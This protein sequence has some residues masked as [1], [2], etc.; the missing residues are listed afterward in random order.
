MNVSTK[1]KEQL[2]N[3]K[4][5]LAFVGMSNSGKSYRAKVLQRELGFYRY[6]IDG[7][8]QADLGFSSMEEI[9]DWM[10]YPD[11]PTYKEREQKYL[12]LENKHT[13]LTDFDYAGNIVFDT[14]GSVVHL[15]Q[16]TKDWL[17][18]NCIVVNMEITDDMIEKMMSAFFEHP[19][20]VVWAGFFN[21]QNDETTQNALKHSYPKL[22]KARAKMYR[23]LAHISVPA[24]V[25]RDTSAQETM[26]IIANYL[27]S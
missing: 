15:P 26:N 20:P 3:N 10:G 23:E 25:L 22:L 9:S 18:Q 2:K 16:N 8:I 7:A 4:L 27:K 13:L 19:K 21:K 11:S 12:E 24:S 1:Y 5:K 6:D 17:H 14:T